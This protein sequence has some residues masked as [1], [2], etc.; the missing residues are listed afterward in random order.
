MFQVET[1]GIDPIP[2][3]ERHGGAKDLF[4]LWFG[5]NLTFTY[6]INGTLAVA[7]GL[8][9]WA[10]V[11]VVVLGGLA[12]FAVGALGLGG[13]RTGTSTLVLSR[14]AFGVLGNLP[15]G[16]LNWV[17]GIGYIILNTVVGTFALEALFAEA[18]WQG[19]DTARALA[20][21]V[22]LALTFAVAMWGHATVQAAERWMAYVLAAG[23]A[24]VIVFVLPDADPGAA[25]G[26]TTFHG[27]TL[28]LVVMV[29]GPVSYLPMPSDYTRYLPRTTSLKAITWSGAIGGMLS[30][31]LLGI[32]GV[33]AATQADMTDPVAGVADL[34]PGWFQALFLFLIVGGSVTNSILTLYSSSLN[35]QV[36]GI[37]WSR[38]AGIVISTA[39]VGAGSLATV[40][41]VDFTESLTS[42][43]SVLLVVFAPWGG[44]FIAD[45]LLRRC[46]YDTAALHDTA[47]GAYWYTRGFHVAGMT[48]LA[49]GIAAAALTAESALWTGPLVAPLGGDFS[50]CGALVA[51]LLYWALARRTAGVRAT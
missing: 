25:A 10:A 50:L 41:W 35:L 29:A 45:T 47:G 6:V 49:A 27:W 42:F 15:A 13:I 9:F 30:S 36:L 48:A 2:D 4:W 3:A 11:S 18:G 5:S 37:P 12:F 31:V 14:A 21:V 20:L 34:L 39:F 44:V 26:G 17:V 43:L 22:T 7:F 19:G 23:F 24:L 1:H 46:R 28:A 32:L 33:A 8:S 16:L 38:S 51:G 40:F